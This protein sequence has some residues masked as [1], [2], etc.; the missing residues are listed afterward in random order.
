MT[1]VYTTEALLRATVPVKMVVDSFL[2]DYKEKS[3]DSSSSQS[4]FVS[5]LLSSATTNV[6]VEVDEV[7]EEGIDWASVEFL[8]SRRYVRKLVQIYTS[9]LGERGIDLEDDNLAA[10]V[11]HLSMSRCND[12]VP[13]PFSPCNVT[14]CTP[15]SA[16]I[17]DDPV[18]SPR[19]MTEKDVLR[20]RTYPH[21]N[22][23]GV[24]RVWEAG[25]CLAEYIARYPH[26]VRNRNVVELGAGVGLT[27]LVAAGVAH[28]Q[29]VHMTDY[30]EACLDN[31][32]HNVRENRDWL[33]GRSVHP[34]NVTVG[35]LEWGQYS[36]SLG[37]DS[38]KGIK[39]YTGE[40]PWAD[41]N[42][43]LS[44][45]DVLLAADVVYDANCI[46]D[47][48]ATVSRFLSLIENTDASPERVAIFATTFRNEKTF[49]L[50]E[51]ELEGQNIVC[52]YDQS[53]TDLP[54]IFPCY[55]NQPRTDVRVCTMKMKR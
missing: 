47:L 30:T 53:T 12:S 32:A 50:F 39:E 37:R 11:C 34:K 51:K 18:N 54:N 40:P 55:F 21:H 38:N 13:D 17:S 52:E 46:P 2:S 28:A 23:V 22:D 49:G 24:A 1:S 41:S 7:A 35:K 42:A 15:A 27:G 6:S 14:F 9:Q 19:S 3:W 44:N 45:A 26:H 4:G 36:Q 31:L 20:I 33:I 48:V 8:P 5:L 25:A 16:S 29:S 43:A 10:L